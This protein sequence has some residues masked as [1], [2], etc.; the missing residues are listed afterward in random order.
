VPDAFAARGQ[1]RPAVQTLQ[2]FIRFNGNGYLAPVLA[3]GSSLHPLEALDREKVRAP[4]CGLCS[5]A[6]GCYR[7]SKG[8]DRAA[9]APLEIAFP[10]LEGHR[11]LLASCRALRLGSATL[12]GWGQPASSVQPLDCVPL[13][14]KLVT[15]LVPSCSVTR[16]LV[17]T[18]P[19]SPVFFWLFGPK[20]NQLL[21]R[22][23]NV[24]VPSG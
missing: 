13:S 2:I 17:K 22:P 8:K 1:K 19:G 11:R 21:P 10:D 23:T 20:P 14:E 6:G 24:P 9:A 18:S 16:P 3:D 5:S 15:A 12:L 4:P 7:R